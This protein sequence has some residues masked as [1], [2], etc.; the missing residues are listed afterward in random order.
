MFRRIEPRP[1]RD[2][3]TP[4]EK[5]QDYGRRI[6]ARATPTWFLESGERFSGA[7]PLNEVRRLLDEAS[8]GKR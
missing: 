1:E 4:V 6:G 8:P 3:D 5:L 2:C 7:M